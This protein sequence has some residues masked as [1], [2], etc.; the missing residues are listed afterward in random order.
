[1]FLTPLQIFFVVSGTIILIIA[2]D[3]ARRERFNAL[4]F[5]VFIGVGLWLLIF[6]LFPKV[7]D[8]IGHLVGLQR[9]ADALVYAAIIFLLYFVLL[10]LRKIDERELVFTELVRNMAIEFSPKKHFISDIAFVVPLFNED[11]VLKTTLKDI[12]YTYP[13]ATIVAV[14]DGSNDK[15]RRILDAL[16]EKW[17]QNFITLHHLKNNGQWAALETGFEYIRRYGDVSY[18]VTFDSDWQHDIHELHD[19]LDCFHKDKDLDIALWSRFLSRSA[20]KLPWM[21]RLI[22]KIGIIFTWCISGILLSDTHNWYRVMRRRALDTLRITMSDMSHA[23]E[24]LDIVAKNKLHYC[25]VPV[26]I[27]YNQQLLKKWQSSLNALWIAK[28]ILARKFFL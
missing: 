19:F 24:I 1:M 27:T 12:R 8:Y 18:V 5:L 28:K 13:K 9:W 10:L 2:L 25:E 17:D 14:N 23:S 4:H 6:T 21:R 7:L 26:T 20:V 11:K 15:S 3:V 16:S 22:L